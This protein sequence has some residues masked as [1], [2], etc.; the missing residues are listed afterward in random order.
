MKLASFRKFPAVRLIGTSTML[1]LGL[2]SSSILLIA[3]DPEADA[4]LA[5]ARE[6]LGSEAKLNG[7]QSLRFIGTVTTVNG[8]SSTLDIALKKPYKQLQVFAGEK[9]VREIGLNDYEAWTK[10][11]D[12]KDPS[13]YNLIPH[14]TA[15]LKRIRATTFENLYFF[16]PQSNR[17]RKVEYVDKDFYDGLEIHRVKVSYGDV[18]Y[19]RYIEETTG[20]LVLTEVETGERIIEGGEIFSGAIRFPQ[21]LTTFRDGNEVHQIAFDEIQVNPDLDDSLFTLPPLP[22]LKKK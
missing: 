3:G 16:S 22:G 15:A 12:K 13:R 1:V 19:L 8:E 17:W 5:K 10:V 6:R 7:V 21:T 18:F 14:T 20:R 9:L 4:I 11:Y 2:I